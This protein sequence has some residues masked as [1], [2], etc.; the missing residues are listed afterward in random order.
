MPKWDIHQSECNQGD[1]PKEASEAWRMQSGYCGI[2][3]V[4]ED[5]TPRSPLVAGA[6]RAQVH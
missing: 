2:R 6:W 5:M 4:R 3:K 1:M